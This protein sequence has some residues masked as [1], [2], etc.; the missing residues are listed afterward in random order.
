MKKDSDSFNAR[1]F[2]GQAAIRSNDNSFNA[3]SLKGQ[4]AMEYLMTYGLALFVIVIVLAFLAFFLP[5]LIKTPPSCLFSQQGLGCA[6]HVIVYNKTSGVDMV[7]MSFENNLGQT[8]KLEKVA[9]TNVG[10][11]EITKELINSIGADIPADQQN[12]NSGTS[13]KLIVPCKDKN[14]NPIS[15]GPNTDFKGYVAITYKYADDIE[16]A[17][18]RVAIATITGQVVESD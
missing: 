11:G 4:A 16:G 10:A 3:R 9:C 1:G 12:M 14:G 17:P 18:S 5:S 15:N 8:I 6:K 7:I 13:K 2:K